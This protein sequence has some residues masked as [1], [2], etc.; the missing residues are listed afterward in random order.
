M[1][2]DCH[3][4]ERYKLEEETR[5]NL[6]L[7]CDEIEKKWHID[8]FMST[9]KEYHDMNTTLVKSANEYSLLNNFLK[10]NQNLKL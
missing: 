1:T 8:I 5:Q 6:C 10:E 4:D 9:H 3:K 2:G 7:W